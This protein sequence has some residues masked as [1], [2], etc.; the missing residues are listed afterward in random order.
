LIIYIKYIFNYKLYLKL[1]IFLSLIQ[2]VSQ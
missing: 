1:A 2:L